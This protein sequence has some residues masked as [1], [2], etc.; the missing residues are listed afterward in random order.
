MGVFFQTAV[1]K[2]SHFPHAQCDVD[3]KFKLKQLEHFPVAVTPKGR[4]FAH[5]LDREKCSS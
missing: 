1:E 2:D 5:G 3:R 4:Q